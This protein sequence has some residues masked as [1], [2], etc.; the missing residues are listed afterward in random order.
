MVSHLWLRRHLQLAHLGKERGWDN[1][2]VYNR[3]G[4]AG[5]ADSAHADAGARARRAAWR[6]AVHNARAH[7]LA[8]AQEQG[9]AGVVSGVG[10]APGCGLQRGIPV[11][12]LAH[13][14]VQV[15]AH[16]RDH[17]G[18]QRCVPVYCQ[19]VVPRLRLC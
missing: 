6:P 16:A 11:W 7:L 1:E 10:A 13:A 3:L 15:A 18:G 8:E 19:A 12:Q 9:T 2:V 14:R 4:A 17:A 5:G